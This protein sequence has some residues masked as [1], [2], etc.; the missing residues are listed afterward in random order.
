MK[1]QFLGFICLL[2]TQLGFSQKFQD[3]IPFRNDLGLIIIPITFNG[4]EK[5]FAFDTGAEYSVAYD[6][7]SD[8]LK[9]TNKTLNVESSSGLRS[10]MRFYNS[11]VINIGGR[12]ITG[13][14]ILNTA[15]NDIFSCH[16]VDGILGVDIIKELNWKIDFK[17][18]ILVMYP[19]NHFPDSLNLMH[20]LSFNFKD[21]R[22]YIYLNR[23]KSRFKFLLDTGAGKSSNISQRDYNLTNINDLKQIELYSGNFD[24]NGV[25][26]TTKPKVF[27]L[28]KSTSK[29]VTISPIIYYN[30]LKSS[31]I[32]NYLWRDMSLFLSLKSNKLYASSGDI[33]QTYDYY[34]CYVSYYN[35]TMRIMSIVKGSAL[36]NLGVRQ[37]DE[38]LAYN[39]KQ[40]SDFCS[41]DKYQREQIKLEK[42]ITIKLKDGKTVTITKHKDVINES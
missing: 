38:V 15:K 41:L 35:D 36:W 7:A 12:K 42:P 14:R 10:K 29:D 16:N 32:G 31:K 8:E 33:T 28:P 24:V 27:R 17:Q 19:A 9:K 4:V 39:G 3:T 40:F 1:V 13:H 26:T 20:Q 18:K 23:K 11:G 6:W 5:E 30:N 2:L 22:P 25:Y 21:N 34:P 37:G